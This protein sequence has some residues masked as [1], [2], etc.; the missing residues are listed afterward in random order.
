MKVFE[1]SLR[2]GLAFVDRQ[3]DF[4]TPLFLRDMG[5][6]YNELQRGAVW[7]SLDS[8]RKPLERLFQKQIASVLDAARIAAVAKASSSPANAGAAVASVLSARLPKLYRA[9]YNRTTGEFAA[10]ATSIG[11]RLLGQGSKATDVDAEIE[12]WITLQTGKNIAA[13]STATVARVK[14]ILRVGF[15]NGL[16]TDAL[17][18]KLGES[19]QFS[20]SRSWRIARTEVVAASN[21]GNDITISK[22]LPKDQFDKSWLSS[23]D[24]RVRDTHAGADGKVADDK[25]VF[26]L[27]GGRLR[28][29]GDSSMGA[30]ASEIVNCRCTTVFAPKRRSRRRR[31]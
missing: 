27:P 21:A 11:N 20:L 13:V 15:T 31:R 7:K 4:A 28:F 6:R 17:A 25:G 18:K 22:M 5:E 29:P 24:I 9:F 19:G 12:K 1:G 16:T 10:R 30:S 2:S 23:R 14:E 26:T 3:Y 8:Q